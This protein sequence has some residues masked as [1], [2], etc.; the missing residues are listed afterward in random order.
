M[1]T[2]RPQDQHLVDTEGG[3]PSIFFRWFWNIL[4]LRG[5][6]IALSL[7]FGVVGV[8]VYGG[9]RRDLFPDLTLPTLQLLIQSPGRSVLSDN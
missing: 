7:V 3:R 9:L 5:W 4:P 2:E 1:R 6:V 8:V